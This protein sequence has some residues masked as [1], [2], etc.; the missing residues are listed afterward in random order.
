MKESLLLLIFW[1]FAVSLSFGQ[2]ESGSLKEMEDHSVVSSKYSAGKQLIKGVWSLGG[3]L[4]AKSN[5]LTDIDLLIVDVEKFDQRAFHLRLE[6]SYFIKE[7]MAVGAGFHFGE[8]KADLEVSLLNNSY[9]RELHN[10]NRSFGALGFIKNHISVM[11]N[12]VVFITNQTE[13]FYGFG[14]G[15]SETY[16]SGILER[17]YSEKHSMGLSIRPGILIFFTNNFAFDINMGVLGFS[18][19]IEDVSYTYP[20]NNPPSESNRK[21]DSQN[22]STDLNLKFDLLKVGFGFS[23]YF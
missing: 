6:G 11:S 15:P 8:D 13:L 3:T 19:T 18:H 12:N 4:S 21:K 20:T 10:F 1:A 23:Y 22:K 7:N 9:K 16:I 5:S 17:K 14:S 2:S